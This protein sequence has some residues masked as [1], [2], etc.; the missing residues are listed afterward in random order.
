MSR[1]HGLHKELAETLLGAGDAAIDQLDYPAAQRMLEESLALF[2][3]AGNRSRVARVQFSLGL[4]A[5]GRGDTNAAAAWLGQSFDLFT[6]INDPGW[7][8]GVALYLGLALL[9]YGDQAR[10][11][12]LL[13]ES[14]LITHGAG[15]DHG[16]AQALEGLASLAATEGDAERALRLCN[17]AANV[18]VRL[19]LPLPAFDR[20]WLDAALATARAVLGGSPQ[21][22]DGW[23]TDLDR[24]VQYALEMENEPRRGSWLRRARSQHNARL[25]RGAGMCLSHWDE[26]FEQ[27]F[28][29]SVGAAPCKGHTPLS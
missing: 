24:I 8:A 25:P 11:R 17:A 14:L 15:D 6:E 10:A 7:V 18:R 28:G 13:V 12:A 3:Q 4:V 2:R 9:R 5:F 26:L 21:G 23:A 22:A 29:T 19:G 27:D 1:A 16:V 20:V